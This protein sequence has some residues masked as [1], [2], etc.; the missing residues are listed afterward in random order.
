M[1]FCFITAVEIHTKAWT[2]THEAI[3]ALIAVTDPLCG[4]ASLYPCCTSPTL[5]SVSADLG[6]SHGGL[7]SILI[8][9]ASGP[10]S[11]QPGLGYSHGHGSRASMSFDTS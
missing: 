1:G 8:P 4:F 5:S 2:E 7:T 10:F 6:S 3:T 11:I 9:E